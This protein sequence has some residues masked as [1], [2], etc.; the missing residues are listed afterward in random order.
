M[1]WQTT[2]KPTWHIFE[3][4]MEVLLLFV[5][6]KLCGKTKGKVSRR[7]QQSS[8]IINQIIEIKKSSFMNIWTNKCSLLGHLQCLLKYILS[9]LQSSFR[10]FSFHQVH[11]VI[12]IVQNCSESSLHAFFKIMTKKIFVPPPFNIYNDTSV[13]RC[14]FNLDTNMKTSRKEWSKLIR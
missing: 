7:Y 4:R 13:L 3:M 9:S 12:D 11:M 14:A 8:I 2:V 1:V 6:P 10:I 5:R